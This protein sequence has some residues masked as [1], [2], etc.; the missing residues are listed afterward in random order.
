MVGGNHTPIR[1]WGVFKVLQEWHDCVAKYCR[2][3]HRT[4]DNA[5]QYQNI[6][7]QISNARKIFL[8][9][10]HSSNTVGKLAF[11]SL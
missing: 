11:D 4:W 3:I 7:P 1:G 9:M 2:N 10:M 8:R 6:L 5:M